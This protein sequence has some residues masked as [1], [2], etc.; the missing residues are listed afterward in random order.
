MV[1]VGAGI[2]LL[3]VLLCLITGSVAGETP[4]GAGANV[5]A[6]V[7]ALLYTLLFAIGVILAVAGT[8]RWVLVRRKPPPST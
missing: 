8:V 5:G 2:I 7:L 3:G 1:R 4:P 6:G